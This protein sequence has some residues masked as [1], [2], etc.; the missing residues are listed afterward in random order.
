MIFEDIKNLEEQ[1]FNIFKN[2]FFDFSGPV[3]DKINIRMKKYIINFSTKIESIDNSCILIRVVV[4]WR[5]RRTKYVHEIKHDIGI[6]YNDFNDICKD[7]NTLFTMIATEM[8]YLIE[9]L[10]N[11]KCKVHC[12]RCI[13]KE[14][15]RGTILERYVHKFKK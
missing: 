7:L 12:S 13:K 5:H 3:Y 2:L 4:I 6:S 15:S 10:Q 11:T 1:K 14:C 8:F 9:L